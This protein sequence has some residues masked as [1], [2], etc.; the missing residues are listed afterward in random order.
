[1]CPAEQDSPCANLPD[2]GGGALVQKVA[3]LLQLAPAGA[4]IVQQ[5]AQLGRIGLDVG[6]VLGELGVALEHQHLMLRAT[7]LPGGIHL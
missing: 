5:I 2:V 4:R 3:D 7:G 1:M 6:I